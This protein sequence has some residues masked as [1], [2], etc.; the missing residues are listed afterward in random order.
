[1]PIQIEHGLRD[2][3]L[4][5]RE[6]RMQQK[7]SHS[8]SSQNRIIC[9]V[10]SGPAILNELKTVTLLTIDIRGF[11]RMAKQMGPQQT[12]RL[13]NR[14]FAATGEIVFRHH[15]MVDKY[16]GD[17]FL[18]VFGVPNSSSQDADSGVQA[19]LDMQ[20]C[21]VE[22]NRGL[23]PDFGTTI[24]MG[25]SVHTGEV[26]AG[27]I[28]FEKKMDY[29]VIGD[30][31]NIV[32]RMQSLVKAFPNGILVSGTTLEALQSRFRVRSIDISPEI[33]RD[34]GE[35][36]VYEVLEHEAPAFDHVTD[37]HPESAR[38]ASPS[39]PRRKPSPDQA[40]PILSP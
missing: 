22:L 1:M 21:L 27:H 11:S 9:G 28:G 38:L 24:Q 10:E 16:L 3:T 29:T 6:R 2:C 12:V 32:F 37:A 7:S 15:G 36:A 34:V 39:N 8:T 20:R 40:P 5:D 23:L 18:A 14:F 17:G 30:A 31:V 35:L 13:L 26:V 25:V 33:H 19:A 4:F